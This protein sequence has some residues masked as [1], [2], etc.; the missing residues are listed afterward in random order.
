VTIPVHVT[1]LPKQ[2][3]QLSVDN[4]N[5]V[6]KA[7]KDGTIVVK[8]ARQFDYADAFK[9]ELVLPANV[10]GLSTDKLIIPAGMNEIKMILRVPEGTTPANLQNLVLRATAV[11]NGNVTLTHEIKINVTIAK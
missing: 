1:V 2:V 3:A 4:A 6:V 8:V 5:P 9:V 7:G 10:K 11:V